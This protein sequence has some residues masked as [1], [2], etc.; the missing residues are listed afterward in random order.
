MA[1]LIQGIVVSKPGD[2]SI[3]VAV[4]QAKM[5][6]VYKK[7]YTRTSKYMAHDE[8]NQANVGDMVEVK[9]VKP[10]SA[11][12][13]FSLNRIV[14]ESTLSYRDEDALAGVEKEAIGEKEKSEEPA[15]EEK[16]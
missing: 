6:P 16:K 3:S 11:R 8:K 7:R 2:K 13:R 5:H 9:E 15:V 14:T 10:I 12:K 4:K 1:R